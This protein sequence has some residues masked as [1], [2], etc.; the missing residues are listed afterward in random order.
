MEKLCTWCSYQYNVIFFF[1][2]KSSFAPCG[3]K[4]ASMYTWLGSRRQ[5]F[6]LEV[7]L[8]H[9]LIWPE[10]TR[11]QWSTAGISMPHAC[12]HDAMCMYYTCML[13]VCV[14]WTLC[15]GPDDLMKAF[16]DFTGSWQGCEC[17]HASWQRDWEREM[18]DER[19][20]RGSWLIVTLVH[21]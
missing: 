8:S 2:F 6:G 9:G 1:K 7:T 13:C 5:L 17:T 20:E 19:W 10:M 15:I 18:R 12:M 4:A 16:T 11:V 21:K 14:R 3:S